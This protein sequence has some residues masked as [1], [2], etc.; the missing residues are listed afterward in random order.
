MKKC[1]AD[2]IVKF[3]NLE[4][5]RGIRAPGADKTACTRR[6][7][8]E[9]RFR[10]AFTEGCRR[11]S[12]AP[13]ITD[14]VTGLTWARNAGLSEFPLSWPEAHDF[15]GALN[16]SGFSG[17]ETWRLPQRD[18]LFSL[19]S[20]RCINPALPEGHPFEEVFNGY[21]W[22]A[23]PSARLPEQAWYVHLGGGR[24]QRGMKHGSYMVWPVSSPHRSAPQWRDRFAVTE[25]V[26]TD[27]RTRRMW[28]LGDGTL[29]NW[30]EAHEAVKV[31][32]AE[33]RAGFDSWRLPSI[34]ELDSITDMCRHSP[35]AAAGFPADGIPEGLWS[36]TTSAYETSYAWVLYTRDGALGVG[37]KPKG[38]F[39]FLA[40]RRAG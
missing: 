21:Y 15:V 19:I 12:C 16:A 2:S 31:C 17:I 33:N 8:L 28:L 26:V 40:V 11:N 5:D 22:T 20:H 6:F 23:T 10:T 27:R 7:D 39:G 18:E 9:K 30:H 37:H 3:M 4:T 14:R 29:F 36:A 38:E 25:G 13:V 34:R 32:G 24:V 1:Y 35:A